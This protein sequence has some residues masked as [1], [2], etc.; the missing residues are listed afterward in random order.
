MYPDGQTNGQNIHRI[1]PNKSVESS[2][3]KIRPLLMILPWKSCFLYSVPNDGHFELVSFLPKQGPDSTRTTEAQLEITWNSKN[4]PP[5]SSIF[6]P[7]TTRN[8]FLIKFYLAKPQSTSDLIKKTTDIWSKRL[9]VTSW[10]SEGL[11]FI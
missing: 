8:G 10:V 9:N 1:G 11:T 5:I 6:T 2:P 4:P 3:K 7:V